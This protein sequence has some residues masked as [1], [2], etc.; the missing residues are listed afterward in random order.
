M[1]L[2]LTFCLLS[3]HLFIA[4]YGNL[5]T[6]AWQSADSY[7]VPSDFPE[8]SNPNIQ[9]RPN[10]GIAFTGG[11]SRSYL[12][13][14]GYLS[15]LSELGLIPNIRYLTGISGGSWATLTFSYS[16][17][18]VD[19]STLLGP[20]V[21]PSDINRDDL[22]K[23]DPSCVRRFTQ[24]NF[25]S[26]M[27]NSVKENVTDGL[28]DGWAYATQETYF[29]PVGVAPGA[30]FSWDADTVADIKS[31]NPSL[32]DELFLLPT[33]VNR[34]FPIVGT[35]LVGPTDG[36]PYSSEKRNFT[37]MEVTPLYIGQ[38]R[39]EDVVYQYHL[40]RN[41]TIRMGG[42]VEPF[43]FGRYGSA[44][45]LGLRSSEVSGDLS[46]PEPEEVFDIRYAGGASSYAPGALFE[47]LPDDLADKFGLHFD[48]W[49]PADRTPKSRDTLFCDGGSYENMLLISLL[50]RRVEK[51][52]LFV[53]SRTPLQTSEKWDVY[54]D[55]PSKE[56]ITDKLSA[57]FGVY[58][59]DYANWEERSFDVS[60]IQ[61]FSQ[62]DWAPLVVA[63]QEAQ[64]A[65]NG[66]IATLNLTTV[67]NDWWGVPA[68]VK[69]QITFVYLGRLASWESE[70]SEE[71]HDLLV[72]SD[73]AEAADLS[74]DVDE[75]PFKGFPHY[76]TAGGII[77]Y[78]R[79][80]VLSDMAGWTVLK[81]SELF[82]SIFS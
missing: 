43:A 19:D 35:G 33:N 32:E 12:A 40:G 13:S 45:L 78:E 44:P 66:I 59:S 49:S 39:T 77:N 82:K 47:T 79:A 36:S 28:A 56:Q 27:L 70:L 20:I 67:H 18:D 1:N 68:G 23:M 81:N 72:P 75:G 73:P 25:V 2:I 21:E 60:K 17:L 15:A 50:Q 65:G 52:V 7:P 8:L 38:L 76:M 37:M 14:I 29:A 55:A 64:A 6:T 63:L 9:A 53:N 5:K 71:M 54:N 80:N 51:I 3:S 69:S 57:F 4:V 24:T 30:R 26:L 61:V 31:R 58:P 22:Q 42:A 48:Y 46:V 10:T 11:G 41:H 34:P 62:D 74:V 16:Q